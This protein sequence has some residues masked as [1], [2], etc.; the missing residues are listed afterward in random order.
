MV[1]AQPTLYLSVVE[2]L[3]VIF[4]KLTLGMHVPQGYGTGLCASVC[5]CQ[6]DTT[7]AEASFISMLEPRYIATSIFNCVFS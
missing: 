4:I 1:A 6:F 3:F 5:V 2:H 7:L